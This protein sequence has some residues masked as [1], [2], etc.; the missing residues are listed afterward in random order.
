[1]E[2]KDGTSVFTND[3]KTAGRLRQVVIDPQNK[4]VTHIVIEK[5]FLFTEDKVVPV[6]YVVSATE[7]RIELKC[8][9]QDVDEMSPLHFESSYPEQ[10]GADQ[11][12]P[13]YQV[14]GG[15]FIN[16]VIM[17]VMPIEVRRTISA[18]LVAL[19]EGADVTSEDDEHLGSVERYFTVA[20]E[21]LVDHFIVSGG[22]LN[23]TRKSVKVDW[24]KAIYDDEIRLGITAEQY[25]SLPELKE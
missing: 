7:E 24:V 14:V 10:E 23:K 19:E 9:G 11:P 22:I 5:G 17:P 18:D 20:G 6:D 25:K 12:L 2:L 13:Y 16:P 21:D 15:A 4:V 8:S 3:G 1:M